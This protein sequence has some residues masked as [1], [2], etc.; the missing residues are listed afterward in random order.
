MTGG[1]SGIGQR[2]LASAQSVPAGNASEQRLASDD[3]IGAA[4]K[5]D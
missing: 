5:S 4:W 2:Y 3:V 1:L